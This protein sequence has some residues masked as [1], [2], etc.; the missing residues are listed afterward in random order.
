MLQLGDLKNQYIIDCRDFTRE[1]LRAYREILENHKIP[2]YLTNAKFDYKFILKHLGIRLR[3]IVDIMLQD[4]II[5]CGLDKKSTLKDLCV[6][7]LPGITFQ[8]DLFDYYPAKNVALEFLELGDKQFTQQQVNYGANDVIYP[9]AIAN[10][11]DVLIKE[12]KLKN[13]IMVENAY[14][15]VLAEMEL[16]GFHLDT[17]KWLRLY[18]MNMI[19]LEA[20]KALL[21]MEYADTEEGEI[22]WNSPKQ[23]GEYFKSIGVPVVVKDKYTKIE[24]ITVGEKHLDKYKDQFE[25]VKI[26]IKYKG[27]M[28]ATGTYGEVFFE[29]INVKTGRIHSNFWQI[30]NTGRISSSKPNLQNIPSG[31]EWRACWTPKNPDSHC[32][33]VGD[34]SGQEAR[35][36]ADFANEKKMLNEFNHGTGDMHSLTGSVIYGR[37]ITKA[38]PKERAIGKQTNFLMNYGGGAAGLADSL[39]IPIQ[40]ASS[41]IRK[42][43]KGYSGLTRYFKRQHKLVKQ[44]GFILIDKTTNRRSWVKAYPRWKR[45]ET[46][47]DRCNTYNIEPILELQNEYNSIAAKMERDSQNYPIQ[48]SSASM[49]KMAAVYLYNWQLENDYWSRFQIVNMVHDEIVIECKKEYAIEVQAKLVECMELAGAKFCDKLVLEVGCEISDHWTH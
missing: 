6:R 27:L 15:K 29:N 25:I 10:A 3:N 1:E 11:Q 34:F 46:Y 48:G 39:R 7:Y 31:S 21:D 30:K 35:V 38:D 26:Y 32:L 17:T 47:L 43:Y 33:I 45:V 44:R 37:N 36:L 8:Q 40:R 18:Y 12:Y 42:Y 2:K 9:I 23:V 16:N 22:N 4:R 14:V 13:T 28:K 49:T 41:I 5:W 20:T 24:K 19:N